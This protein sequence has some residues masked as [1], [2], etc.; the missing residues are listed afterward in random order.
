MIIP[1]EDISFSVISRISSYIAHSPVA[2]HISHATQ[3]SISF[4]PRFIISVSAPAASAD[5]KAVLTR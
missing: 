2:L 1:S 4:D 3:G 5:F